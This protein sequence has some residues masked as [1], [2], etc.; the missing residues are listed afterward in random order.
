MS[1]SLERLAASFAEAPTEWEPMA[2]PSE[3]EEVYECEKGCGFTGSCAEVERHEATCWRKPLAEARFAAVEPDE[4]VLKCDGA[5]AHAG[6]IEALPNLSTHQLR[7]LSEAAYAL[8]FR[9][10][11]ELDARP[12][13]FPSSLPPALVLQWL[14]V[15]DAAAALRVCVRWRDCGEQYF[16]MFARRIGYTSN[17][18][19]RGEVRRF[20][21]HKR[22][23][24]LTPF[25]KCVLDTYERLGRSEQFF[26]HN[27]VHIDA[28]VA[29]LNAQPAPRGSDRVTTDEVRRA[30]DVLISRHERD[31]F[32]GLTHRNLTGNRIRY[33]HPRNLTPFQWKVL[34][35]H[36]HRRPRIP[37]WGQRTFAAVFNMSDDELIPVL[38]TCHAY[39]E[40][41]HR[42]DEWIR[43]W[44]PTMVQG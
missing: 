33:G 37:N 29:A 26:T 30:V 16:R 20:V 6:T 1:S 44:H 34:D 38:D 43:E 25:Q 35:Y 40:N 13:S 42:L 24:G 8:A 19:I 31:G 39:V 7:K 28:V 15:A 21:V 9:I 22:A 14:P 18:N 11:D 17:V 36:Y 32:V 2:E 10:E 5:V 3:E 23:H 4:F 41:I 12:V 27:H